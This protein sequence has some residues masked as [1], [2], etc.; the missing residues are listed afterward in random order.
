MKKNKKP[1]NFWSDGL[2]IDESKVSCL[3]I[4]LIFGMIFVGYS[5]L[6][7][8]DISNNLADIIIALIYGVTG[9]NVASSLDSLM[10]NRQQTKMKQ[11]E[12]EH[13]LEM[14]EKVN[15]NSSNNTSGNNSSSDEY[16][17]I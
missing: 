15:S 3:I 6:K 10:S 16:I 14:Q 8:Q 1:K 11:M 5:Y 4:C 9:I 12:M 17:D 2:S 13:E 7:F